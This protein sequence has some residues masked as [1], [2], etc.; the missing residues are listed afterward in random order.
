MTISKSFRLSPQAIRALEELVSAGRAP[1]Q[2]ALIEELIRRERLKLELQMEEQA[3]DAEWAE[4][5]QDPVFREDLEAVER[6][7]RHADSEAWARL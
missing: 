4:A 3:L 7:F 6:D 2:T 5:M 1:S